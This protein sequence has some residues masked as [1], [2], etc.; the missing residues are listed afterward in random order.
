MSGRSVE[1]LR[2]AAATAHAMP[3]LTSCSQ[4]VPHSKL[5]QLPEAGLTVFGLDHSIFLALLP[6]MWM[7]GCG[8]GAGD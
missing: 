1:L 7:A 3:S 5:C 4:P 6:Y 8:M 2:E